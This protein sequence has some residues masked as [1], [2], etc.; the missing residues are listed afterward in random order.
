MASNRIKGITI[1]IG[2]DTTK[3][4]KALGG[5]DHN[6]Y[7]IQKDLKAVEAALKLD[8]GNVDLLAQKHRLLEEAVTESA[9]KYDTLTQ[10][11]DGANQALA[12]GKIDTKQ[13]HNL[14]LETDLA[15]SSLTQAEKALADFN[16]ELKRTDGPADDAADAIANMGDASDDAAGG[17]G[18]L[19]DFSRGAADA[20]GVTNIAAAGVAFTIGQMLVSAIADAAKE[21]WAMDEATEEYRIAMGKLNTAFETAGYS[22][23]TAKEAYQGFFRILGD[24]D[25]ATEASQLL[26]KLARDEEDMAHWI[27]IAAGVY[28][29]F[30]DSLPI[31]GLIEA[32]NETK[33]VGKVT[34][35]L[36]DALNWAG[37]SEDDFN[38]TLEQNIDK[39]AR[40]DYIMDTLARTYGT[41]ADEFYKNNEALIANRDSQELMNETSAE[42][43]QSVAD[44]KAALDEAFGPSTELMMKGAVEFFNLLLGPI[45]AIG[46]AVQDLMDGI[47]NAANWL[48]R[49]IGQKTELDEHW[50]LVQ[51]GKTPVENYFPQSDR[52]MR[53]TAADLPHLARGTVT[54]PNN[55]FMAV[56]GDN[57]T[58]PEV[59]SPYSTIRRAAQD[60]MAAGG[61]SGPVSVNITF[62]GDLAQLARVLNPHIEVENQRLGPNLVN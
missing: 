37:I 51:P 24:V 54:R 3:L 13:Y 46:D 47:R 17:M 18:G 12:E 59:I 28:G 38:K 14:S 11:V 15:E 61:R 62:G 44:V 52:T 4:D 42:L 48:R 27:D 25:T 43:G 1:E 55:P 31:E 49:L 5:V 8:P 19:G 16:D 33:E 7:T 26:S 50:N 21:L 23:E 34:G 6:L 53:A 9:K 39:T 20:L 40:A 58:E 10:A 32:A 57:P 60:A 2:G 29:T 30:G 35:V 36:A 45:E 22:A 56:V 41:A